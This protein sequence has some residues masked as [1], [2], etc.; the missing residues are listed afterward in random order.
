MNHFHNDKYEVNISYTNELK[1]KH[2]RFN[3]MK[4]IAHLFIENMELYIPHCIE[5]IDYFIYILKKTD[6]KRPN[7]NEVM[8]DFNSIQYCF[9]QFLMKNRLS[10]PKEGTEKAIK[11]YQIFYRRLERLWIY[12]N[13]LYPTNPNPI[14]LSPATGDLINF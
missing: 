3:E 6:K 14:V 4:H 1:S 11:L 7:F 5:E 8:E 9:N 10:Y 13:N 12:Y 2:R